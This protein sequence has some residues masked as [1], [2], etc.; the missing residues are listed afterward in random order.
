MIRS[1]IKNRAELDEHLKKQEDRLYYYDRHGK[2]RPLDSELEGSLHPMH[3]HKVVASRESEKPKPYALSHSSGDHDL[4]GNMLS[5][6]KDIN[7]FQNDV[8]NNVYFPTQLRKST[9]ALRQDAKLKQKLENNLLD[10]QN[11]W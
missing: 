5:K 9:K 8:A 2:N 1:T 4:A 3:K 11:S 10:P 6:N 7:Q